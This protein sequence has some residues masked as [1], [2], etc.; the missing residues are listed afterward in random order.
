MRRRTS[1]WPSAAPRTPTYQKSRDPRIKAA[2]A[3]GPW[4]MQGGFWDAEG[5]KGIRTPVMFVAGSMR[6]CVGIRERHARDLPGRGECRSL[7]ADVHQRQSQRRGAVSRRRLESYACVRRRANA[8]FT[9]YADAVWD[10]AR[11][12]NIFHHF[13]TAYFGVYLKGEADKQAYLDVVPNGKDAVYAMDR[14]GK[15]ARDAHLLEGLQARHG[16]RP[17]PRAR[18][19]VA[20]FIGHYALAFGAKRLA[21]RC[22]S[23][24]CSSRA[25][26]PICCGR[27][28]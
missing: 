16:R 24:R 22:R 11:M 20:M 10:T 3:I 17:D 28:S 18:E 1:C 26:S 23:A 9:H 4:G 19:A 8:P 14:D 13:A 5:L 12:N 6:R 25:S 27:R 7:P 15:P 2:I 21:P